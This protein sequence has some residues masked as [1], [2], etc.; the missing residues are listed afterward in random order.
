VE[1][2]EIVV[3]RG[4]GRWKVLDMDEVWRQIEISDNQLWLKLRNDLLENC[5]DY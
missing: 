5:N 3:V 2:E 1:I 4:V